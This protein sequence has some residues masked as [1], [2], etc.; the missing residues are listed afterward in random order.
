MPFKAY[1]ITSPFGNRKH[2]IS[3]RNSFHTGIDLVK[4]KGGRNAPI[5]AFTS[6][7]VLF[8][9]WGAT[10][11]GFGGYGNV[12][13]IKDKNNR[14][15]VYAH[16][17][18]VSVRK[19]QVIKKGQAIGRQGNTGNSTGPHLHYEVRKKAESKVPFGWISDRANN[20]LNPTSYLK[21]FDHSINVSVK[22]DAQVV[23]IQ[24]W[25]GSTPD[26]IPGPDTWKQLTKK[27]QTELNK[28]FNAGLVVDG[29][30]G[31]KTQAAVVTIRNGAR[32]NLTKV[33]QSALYLAGYTSVGKPDGVFGKNTRKALGSRSEE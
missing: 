27:L 3:G 12:V 24:K 13:L 19:G 30:W 6:G 23:D 21:E 4:L 10:G 25:V 32:G 8:A 33:L 11:T 14:G 7:T 1:R 18:S 22:V 31:P 5:E 9:G 28:Q 15:Q 26:G 20:C 2:P 16:L 17:D 29:I